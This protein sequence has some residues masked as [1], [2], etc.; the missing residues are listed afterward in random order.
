MHESWSTACSESE[1]IM[2]LSSNCPVAKHHRQFS[3]SS[4][5]SNR[6]VAAPR[7][8]LFHQYRSKP[9]WLAPWLLISLRWRRLRHPAAVIAVVSISATGIGD[10]PLYQKDDYRFF[11][12]TDSRDL[13]DL[14]SLTLRI[15]GGQGGPSCYTL[16]KTLDIEGAT[17]YLHSIK[18]L[19]LTILIL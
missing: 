13:L 1:T 4:N 5:M 16:C 11:S 15:W 17:R 19:W 18:W 10:N 7:P 6:A 14:S 2:P 8:G 3:S 9:P 12:L